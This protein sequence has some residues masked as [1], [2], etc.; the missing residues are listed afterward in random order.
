MMNDQMIGQEVSG[1]TSPDVIQKEI[2]KLTPSEKQEARESLRE[3]INLI[4]EL[5]AQG[6]TEEDIQALLAEMG[7]SLEELNFAEQLF[8]EEGNTI[9]IKI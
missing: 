1:M 2:D 5:M 6:A 7:I 8:A 3:I 9:G 4:Q